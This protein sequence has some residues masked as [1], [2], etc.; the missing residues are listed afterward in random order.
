MAGQLGSGRGGG[1]L[2]ERAVSGRLTPVALDL[3]PL[4]RAALA[5]AAL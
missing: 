5:P 2:G 4:G 3:S 1:R